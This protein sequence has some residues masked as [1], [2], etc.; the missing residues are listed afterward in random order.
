MYQRDLLCTQDWPLA[1]LK[2]LLNTAIRL[3]QL[4][5]NPNYRQLFSHK[6][7]LMLFYSPSMRTHLS[8]M[9]AATELGGHAQFLRPEMARMQTKQ[10]FGETIEDVAQVVSGYVAAIGIRMMEADVSGYGQGHQLIREYANYASVPVI[11]MADDVCHPCQALADV[12][13]WAEA[14][15]D[16]KIQPDLSVLQGKTLLMSWAKGRL[17]CSWNSPQ[18][19]LLLASRL[20]MNIRIARPEGYDLDPM[21]YQDVRD[22]CADNQRD[23]TIVSDADSGYSGADVVY[24]R[25]W[26]S[27]SAYENGELQKSKEIERAL[28]YDDWITTS[29]KMQRTPNAIFTHPMPVDR[30]YEVEDAVASGPRS[31]IYPVSHNRLHVQKAVLAHLTNS[32]Q[33]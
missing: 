24:S 33:F 29:E 14:F 13:G 23:F 9:A 26:V 11:N 30:G 15:S 25:H 4:P 31:V 16:N 32:G 5:H 12:L 27:E 8:F 2:A 19:S 28:K 18:A 10:Q 20:G 6:N 1:D 17:A 7:F 3:K 22:N 21:I